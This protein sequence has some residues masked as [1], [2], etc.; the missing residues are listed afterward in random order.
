MQAQL[1]PSLTCPREFKF[2][3]DNSARIF[4]NLFEDLTDIILLVVDDVPDD[5][6]TLVKT[7]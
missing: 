4:L 3:I 1:V 7:S 5:N 6:E 2:S